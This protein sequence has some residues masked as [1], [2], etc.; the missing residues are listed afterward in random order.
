MIKIGVAEPASLEWKAWRKKCASQT[1]EDQATVAAGQKILFTNLYKEPKDF[2]VGSSGPFRGKCAYCEKTINNQ[3]G[4]IEHYRPKAAVQNEDGK[5]VKISHAGAQRDHPGYY[6]LAYDWQNLL[7]SCELCNRPSRGGKWGKGN[8]FPVEGKH[9]ARPGD[10]A[11]ERPK[12]LNPLIDSPADHLAFDSTGTVT[13][14]SERGRATR[15]ILGLDAKDLPRDR[16]RKW[17]EVDAKISRAFAQWTAMG[18]DW[19]VEELTALQ[20]DDQEFA[21][22]AR[23]VC[24]QRLSELLTSIAKVTPGAAKHA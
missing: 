21:A 1:V 14:K 3:Y 17:D 8:R 20:T 15:D 2:Y 7:P 24:N 12:I 5:R 18:G 4:D 23:T 22:V 11:T 10:E 13:P 6:W 9:A 16:K 19:L